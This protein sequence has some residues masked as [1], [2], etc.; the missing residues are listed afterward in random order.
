MQEGTRSAPDLNQ[1]EKAKVLRA[2]SLPSR[3]PF[4]T[5]VIFSM[6]H[7]LGIVTTVTSLVS[8]LVMPSV[9]ASSF[10][11]GGLAFSAISWLLAFFKRRTAY[12]PL[13]KGTPLVNSGAHTHTK[14]FRLLPFNHGTT[15]M[16]SIIATQ[17]FR[18]MYCGSDYDLLKPP[19]RLLIGGKTAE[20][21][22]ARD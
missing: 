11:G 21:V 10:V 14:A 13:C 4:D 19:S 5:A 22:A 20:E 12:C 3:S 17:K 18:C 6:I 15:A 7:Y 1:P 2:R 16:L 8:Y 9:L